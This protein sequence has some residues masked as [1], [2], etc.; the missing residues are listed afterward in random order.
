M[1]EK[2]VEAFDGVRKSTMSVAD[3]EAAIEKV[4]GTSPL[5][6]GYW[7]GEAGMDWQKGDIP[8]LG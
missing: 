1:M 8:E 2:V 4:N 3:A 5:C 7:Y 6:N